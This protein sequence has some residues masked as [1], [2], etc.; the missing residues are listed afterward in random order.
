MAL[1]E[2]PGGSGPLRAAKQNSHTLSAIWLDR[3]VEA[4]TVVVMEHGHAQLR[5]QPGRILGV[6]RMQATRGHRLPDL[7][8][9]KVGER[10]RGSGDLGG[11]ARLEPEVLRRDEAGTAPGNLRRRGPS[12]LT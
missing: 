1:A 9:E 3:F 11:I 5:D 10:L 4:G 8:H 7:L 12:P 6:G 2:G